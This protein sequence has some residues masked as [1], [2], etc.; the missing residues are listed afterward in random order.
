MV[1]SVL[2]IGT[3]MFKILL[4]DWACVLGEINCV[5]S[6]LVTLMKTIT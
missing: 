1:V 6:D 2:Y 3:S 5:S 4:M